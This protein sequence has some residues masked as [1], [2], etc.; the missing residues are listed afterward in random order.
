[1]ACVKN[2]AVSV[3]FLGAFAQTAFSASTTGLADW[4][5][6]S[7]GNI[8]T[9]NGGTMSPAGTFDSTL[10]P[11]ANNL[12]SISFALT[13]GQYA[14]AY[15]DYDLDFVKYGS[16]QDSGATHGALPAAG[17]YELADPNT[18]NIFTDFASN[19]LNN[20]NTV[21]TPSGPPSACCDVS[22]AL[23][24][25]ASV[26]GTV[27]FTVSTTAP[28]S[29]FY[30]QQTSFDAGDSIYLSESF[31]PGKAPPPPPPNVPEPATL[32]LITPAIGAI[33]AWKQLRSRK[34]AEIV[35]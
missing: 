10:E 22:W 34:L 32:L 31:T 13:A 24:Y 3:F 11:S 1:M 4:C 5:F 7:N 28:A 6:N 14:S 21:G 23:S 18:S 30:L 15:M 29:G 35:T 33:F 16:F 27:T 20:T 19:T 25:K 2:L 12:G 9:C 17:S 26:A 8:N